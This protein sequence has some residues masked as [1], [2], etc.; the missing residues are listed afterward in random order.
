MEGAIRQ[1]SSMFFSCA[2]TPIDLTVSF[3]TLRRSKST[4]SSSSFPASIFEKS[5]MSLM[6]RSSDSD[7]S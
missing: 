5:R 3:N 6:M 2:R 7:E 4:E 1:A